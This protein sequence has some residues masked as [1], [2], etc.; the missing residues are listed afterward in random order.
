MTAEILTFEAVLSAS[1]WL[2]AGTL[3]ALAV[4][5]GIPV[6]A[7]ILEYVVNSWNI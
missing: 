3:P 7:F 5:L 1:G 4:A 6:G 2:L